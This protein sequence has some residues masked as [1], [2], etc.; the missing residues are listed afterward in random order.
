MLTFD[1][2]QNFPLLGASDETQAV[3]RTYNA[4]C[5]PGFFVGFDTLLPKPQ[6]RG[7]INALQE[8]PV[9][10]EGAVAFR[11]EKLDA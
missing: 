10:E 7:E 11:L 8:N 4:I 9:P 2:R 1:E 6:F 5:T 3:V